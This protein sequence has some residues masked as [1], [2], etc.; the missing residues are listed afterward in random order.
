MDSSTEYINE[1]FIGSAGFGMMVS[2]LF[3][4][5]TIIFQLIPIIRKRHTPPFWS[6][7][8]S[9]VLNIGYG[10]LFSE[11]TRFFAYFILGYAAFFT[12]VPF[13]Y[14]CCKTKFNCNHTI[15][16]EL[17]SKPLSK[18]EFLKKMCGNRALPP[19]VIVRAEAY[20]YETRTEY[21]QHTDSQ[22]TWT[23]KKEVTEKV[24][25]FEIARDLKYKSWEEGG[26]SIRM[27]E[28]DIIHAFCLVNYELD[29]AA[30]RELKNLRI[31]LDNIASKY[32][33]YTSVTESYVTPGLRERVCGCISDDIACSAKFWQGCGGRILWILFTIIGYQSSIESF[34][35]STGERMRLRLKKKISCE[36]SKYRCGFMEEDGEAA[37]STFR[38]D[39]DI[40]VINQSLINTNYYEGP[41]IDPEY[42]MDIPDIQT[43]EQ[44]PPLQQQQQSDVMSPQYA[45]VPQ[46]QDMQIPPLPQQQIPENAYDPQ[47]E[48]NQQQ[49][50]ELATSVDPNPIEIENSQQV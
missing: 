37:S 41:P 31:K 35:A 40:V 16:R 28:N 19:R 48:E 26:N 30:N 13:D 8:F 23:E 34:W 20:H 43:Y 4:L 32:D 17:F 5:P 45:P 21:I 15:C 50:Q 7:F 25:T 1:P 29:S 18:S 44:T 38:I 9:L 39:R 22:G 46:H 33:T 2:A 42:L 3:M 6:Y 27:K 36:K 24:T 12:I 14:C 47:M 10:L 11:V 49:Q